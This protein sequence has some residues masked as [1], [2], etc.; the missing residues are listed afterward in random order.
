MVAVVVQS[1]YYD[2]V[3]SLAQYDRAEVSMNSRCSTLFGAQRVYAGSAVYVAARASGSYYDVTSWRYV[4]VC[5]T[6]RARVRFR[7]LARRLR[8]RPQ[9]VSTTPRLLLGMFSYKP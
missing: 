7:S 4:H 9:S 2:V 8:Y 6:C 1:T 3:L 5:P